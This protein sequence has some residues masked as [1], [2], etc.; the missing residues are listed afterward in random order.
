VFA[1]GVTIKKIELLDMKDKVSDHRP[2][3]GL[4]HVPCPEALP[5][6]GVAV[7]PTIG[8]VLPVSR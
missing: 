1:R 2:V 6:T 7:N 5:K 3:L 4:I 8:L